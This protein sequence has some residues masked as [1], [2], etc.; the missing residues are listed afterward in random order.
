MM[1]RAQRAALAA[2]AA[3][4]LLA[5]GCGERTTVG[6]VSAPQNRARVVHPEGQTQAADAVEHTDG[7]T[8]EAEPSE[9][10]TPSTEAPPSGGRAAKLAP[11]SAAPISN[12]GY[13]PRMQVGPL[14]NYPIP[15]G[16]IELSPGADLQAAANDAGEGAVF[17]LAPGTYHNASVR[18]KTNQKFIG[19][20]R[21]VVLDGGNQRSVAFDGSG[22][23][24]VTVANLTVTRYATPTQG[25]A[26]DN[27]GDRKSPGGW[28]IEN[29]AAVENQSAG[30]HAGPNTTV[31][32]SVLSRNGKVGAFGSSSEGVVFT[33]NEIAGNNTGGHDAGYEAGGIKVGKLRGARFSHNAV[34]DN[35]G[36]GLWTDVFTSDSRFEGNDLWG[37]ERGIF[38]EIGGGA[39]IIGNRVRNQTS[40]AGWVW[41]A[42]IQVANSGP[43]EVANNHIENTQ[44]GIIGTEQNRGEWRLGAM[45]V[46]NNTLISAGVTGV[47]YDTGDSSVLDRGHRFTNNRYQ[48]S[49]LAFGGDPSWDT[50]QSMGFDSGG[51]FF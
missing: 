9:A 37:N 36:P 33:D 18:P 44:N 31:R 45:N 16:A 15:G 11:A 4:A 21:G 19:R 48:N 5:A 47:K 25:G 20:G 3:A 42:A 13:G 50:W 43:V 46:H 24:G 8:G 2:A 1:H 32:G 6:E 28:L 17:A 14:D 26:I 30:V 40:D 41:G 39:A 10:T 34:F 35:H 22:S 7:G 51:S 23:T 29:V 27:A 38:V 49:R 12:D